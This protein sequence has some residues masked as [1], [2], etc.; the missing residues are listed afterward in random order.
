[1]I[2]VEYAFLANF[3]NGT[4]RIND[5][6]PRTSHSDAAFQAIKC[7]KYIESRGICGITP[8]DQEDNDQVFIIRYAS[9]AQRTRVELMMSG[10]PRTCELRTTLT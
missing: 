4:C 6:F 7:R 2:A 5:S 1:M 9:S 3:N 8:G 10:S